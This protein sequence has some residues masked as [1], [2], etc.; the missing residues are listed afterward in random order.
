MIIYAESNFVLELALLQK[1]HQSC[2]KILSFC[3]TDNIHLLL[4]A[5]C[6]TEPLETLVR[7]AKNRKSLASQLEIE[8]KQ[9]SRTALYSVQLDTLQEVT[10]L[11]LQSREDEMLRLF[12]ELE[13]ILKVAEIIP[14]VPEIL[15]LATDFQ[16]YLKLPP[17]DSIVYASVV[18]H[19]N[20]VDESI[21]KCFLNLNSKDFSHLDI[22]T[23][24]NSHNCKLLFSFEKGYHYIQHQLKL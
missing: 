9:L 6:L 20:T 8:I 1:E 10:A 11:L 14:M 18:H 12:C 15:P 3:E 22:K 4:P 16:K 19:L 23:T 17:Q 24:L 21:P 13:N 7:R 2:Q 5:M